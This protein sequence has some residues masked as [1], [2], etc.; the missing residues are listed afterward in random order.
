MSRKK[1]PTEPVKRGR[2][3]PPKDES[4]TQK[5]CSVR[6]APAEEAHLLAKYGSVNAGVRELVKLDMEST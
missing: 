5:P 3:R 4:G 6:L 1:L 2:G